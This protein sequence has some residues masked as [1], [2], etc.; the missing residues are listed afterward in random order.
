MNK[1]HNI[2]QILKNNRIYKLPKKNEPIVKHNK[3]GKIAGKSRLS[4]NLS[5]EH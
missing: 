4:I 3:V 2:H 1:D 5:K